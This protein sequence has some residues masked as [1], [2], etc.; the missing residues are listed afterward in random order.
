M[1]AIVPFDTQWLSLILKAQCWK[2][3]SLAVAILGRTGHVVSFYATFMLSIIK[4]YFHQLVNLPTCLGWYFID[5]IVTS[6]CNSWKGQPK[7]F[8]WAD[9]RIKVKAKKRSEKGGMREK[10]GFSQ[11]AHGWVNTS[12]L[13]LSIVLLLVKNDKVM[14]NSYLRVLKLT[15]KNYFAAVCFLLKSPK[16]LSTS[17]ICCHRKEFLLFSSFKNA[18]E[19]TCKNTG[20]KLIG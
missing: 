16:F 3:F 14:A 15:C 5:S 1:E 7:P 13:S 18:Q 20:E 4:I 19:V 11:F 10:K 8:K 2:W 17:V 9:I 6:G 12:V